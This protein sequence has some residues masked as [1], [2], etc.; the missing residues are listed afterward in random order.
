MIENIE[1]VYGLI[2]CATNVVNGKKYVGKTTKS[3]EERK[4]EHIEQS[5]YKKYHFYNA[6]KKYGQASFTWE[7]LQNNVPNFMLNTCETFWID[8][9]NT[10]YG[11]YNSTT[12]GEGGLVSEETK[13]KISEATKGEKS[14]M[15]GKTGNKNPM[16]GRTGEEAPMFG[17][18]GEKHP[19]SKPV[20]CLET[21]QIFVSA[22]EASQILNINNS[23][24]SQVC[25][26]KLKKTG[27]LH[28]TFYTKQP[29]EQAS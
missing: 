13:K 3:F 24:I 26:G 29:Q 22:T 2:Y 6:I 23:H 27:G 8:Y 17:R 4:K 28:F 7:V 9:F 16:F 10:F 25:R 18:T 19:S 20:I 14:H 11:G 5:R 1:T 21:N 15:F 12:G